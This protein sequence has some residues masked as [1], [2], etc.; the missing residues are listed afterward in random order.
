MNLGQ[1]S[2]ILGMALTQQTEKAVPAPA[3][4]AGQAPVQA[5]VQGA[6]QAGAE[7]AQQQNPL[8]G[9]LPMLLAFVAIF[10]FMMI[11]PQQKRDKERRDMLAALSKGDAVVTS[12]GICG[13]VSGLSENS[14]VL[15]VDDN[16]TIEFLRSAIVQVTSRSGEAKKK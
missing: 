11:R 12:G 5:A 10:Y 13:T 8:T 7:V 3:Q 6:A 9:M 15:R 16:V 1:L 2:A 14:V 4:A